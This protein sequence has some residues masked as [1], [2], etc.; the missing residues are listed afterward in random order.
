MSPRRPRRRRLVL[1]V[2]LG[3]GAAA[4]GVARADDTRVH[5]SATVEV[6]DDP[7]QIDDVVSRLRTQQA[8]DK[9]RAATPSHAGNLKLERAAPPTTATGD[10]MHRTVGP[11]PKEPHAGS[12]RSNRGPNADPDRTE[13]PKLKVHRR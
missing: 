4:G 2:A 3:L 8:L 1:V 6:L 5:T 9:Q 13:R 7:S 10:S 12:R 11:E